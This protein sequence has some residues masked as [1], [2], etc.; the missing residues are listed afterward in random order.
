MVRAWRVTDYRGWLWSTRKPIC[1]EAIGWE[2]TVISIISEWPHRFLSCARF[3][4]W[5]LLLPLFLAILFLH[6]H[7]IIFLWWTRRIQARLPCKSG[8]L[9]HH[10]V[11]Q[12][13]MNLI[14]ILT[15]NLETFLISILSPCLTNHGKYSTWNNVEKHKAFLTVSRKTI[16][17][18]HSTH[19]NLPDWRVHGTI[20]ILWKYLY[21]CSSFAVTVN[22][23]HFSLFY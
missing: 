4:F 11:I 14:M 2:H 12:L 21:S 5:W 16:Y 18:V 9:A 8:S 13:A 15:V 3:A 19:K 17:S 7:F 22:L 1:V 23:L 6:L 10:A 20:V